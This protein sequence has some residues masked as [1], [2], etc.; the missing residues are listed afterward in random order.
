MSKHL[1][2]YIDRVAFGFIMLIALFAPFNKPIVNYA[3]AGLLLCYLAYPH[4]QFKRSLQ[5]PVVLTC[6]IWITWLILSALFAKDFS[7]ALNHIKGRNW[8]LYP[9]LFYPFLYNQT[10]R[11][12]WALGAL[13]SV[14]LLF[15]VFIYCNVLFLTPQHYLRFGSGFIKLS[16]KS[17]LYP[18]SAYHFNTALVFMYLI[19][20]AYALWNH[21]TSK[22]LKAGLI[23]LGVLALYADMGLNTSRMGYITEITLLFLFF[24]FQWRYKGLISFIVLGAIGLTMLFIFSTTFHHRVEQGYHNTINYYQARVND[25]HDQLKQAAHTSFG[26]RLI[27]LDTMTHRML[28][29]SWLRSLVGFGPGSYS[30][31]MHNYLAN[32]PQQSPYFNIRPHYFGPDNH[33]LK[34]NHRLDRFDQRP[35]LLACLFA[36]YR[37]TL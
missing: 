21:V 25:N 5:H 20:T 18:V 14:F 19:I 35:H 2:Y 1:T 22:W 34:G 11:V 30:Q 9:L 10:R 24:I 33:Y 32:L 13:I 16:A 29:A 12:Q 8:L 4:K 31:I 27:S 17:R 6:L 36:L 37:S 26:N 23:I 7:V 15:L 28:E 3:G